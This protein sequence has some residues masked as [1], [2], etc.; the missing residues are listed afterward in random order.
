VVVDERPWGRFELL[1]RDERAT[2]KIITVVPGGRLSLQ[3]H[4]R[5]DEMWTILD[6]ELLLE[7][8]GTERVAVP[9]EKVWIPRGT[10]HRVSN[11]GHVEGRFLEIAYGEFDEQDI[12]RLDDDYDRA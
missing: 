1:S 10:V 9:G 7:V 4:R 2:V 8:D 11:K 12:E 3:R 5:R 6:V